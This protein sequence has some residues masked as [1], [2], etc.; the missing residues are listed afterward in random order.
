MRTVRQTRIRRALLQALANIPAEYTLRDDL[1]RGEAARLVPA[2]APTTV[3][4]D[5]EIHACDIA[6][7]CVSVPGEEAVQYQI[8]DAGKLWLAK[9]P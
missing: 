9:N 5:A 3:E 8:T 2:P 4:L 1:L 6:R 7:L